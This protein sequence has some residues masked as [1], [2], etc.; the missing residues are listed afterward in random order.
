MELKYKGM[1]KTS[2]GKFSTKEEVLQK[3]K[4]EGHEIVD[5]ILEYRELQKTVIYLYR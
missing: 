3:M 4:N 2:T 5:K 1:R